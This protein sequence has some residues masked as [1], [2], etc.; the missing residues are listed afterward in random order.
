MYRNFF[1]HAKFVEEYR[2][3]D[4][5][6]EMGLD[7]KYLISMAL[8]LGSDY[9]DGV[10]GVGIVN[11]CEVLSSFDGSKQCDNFLELKQFRNWLSSLSAVSKKD[12]DEKNVSEKERF[13]IKHASSRNKWITNEDFP[14]IQVIDAYMKPNVDKSRKS[15]SWARPNKKVLQEFCMNKLSFSE[16]KAKSSCDDL[17]KSVQSMVQPTLG[18]WFKSYADRHL[19]ATVKSERLRRALSHLK[20]KLGVRSNVTT[21]TTTTTSSTT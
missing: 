8:M 14:S 2:A 1:E 16:E 13:M 19:V 11:A 4:L 5:K 10:K 6:C 3:S 18:T 21:T 20:S 9:S 17:M 12:K 7:R 15:F